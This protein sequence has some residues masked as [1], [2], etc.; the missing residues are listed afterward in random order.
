[1]NIEKMNKA[2]LQAMAANDYALEI[3]D[4]MTRQTLIDMINAANPDSGAETPPAGPTQTTDATINASLNEA[5]AGAFKEE[6]AAEKKKAEKVTIIVNS[7]NDGQE[8][9]KVGLNGVMTQIA[10][11]TEVEVSVGILNVLKDA[12]ETRYKLNAKGEHVPYN[13]KRFSFSV[14]G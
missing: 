9:L 5:G 1:M 14:I 6:K 10:F 2:D 13:T 11:D 3:N 12:V 7:P 4:D 8:F